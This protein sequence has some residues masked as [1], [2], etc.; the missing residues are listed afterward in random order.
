MASSSPMPKLP[1]RGRR[2]ILITSALPYVNNVPH[3]G[4]IIGCV[5]PRSPQIIPLLLCVCG[6]FDGSSILCSWDAQVCSAPT[7]SR[8]TAGCV[9]T[10]RS[11]YAGRTST[12]RLLRRKPWRRIARPRKSATSEQAS[13]SAFRVACCC[14]G[15]VLILYGCARAI[16][17][18][19]VLGPRQAKEVSV[20]LPVEQIINNFDRNS[21]DTV[22]LRF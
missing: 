17:K 13:I 22:L 6:S 1:I 5:H 2:N 21:L 8:G 9:G 11:T 14:G 10:T 12:G 19:E 3:L 20:E 4:N 16:L 7:C 15:F 18:W